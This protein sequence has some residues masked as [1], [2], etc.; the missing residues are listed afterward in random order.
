VFERPPKAKKPA[1]VVKASDVKKF[2]GSA[3]AGESISEQIRKERTRLESVIDATNPSKADRQNLFNE[4]LSKLYDEKRKG[5]S[6]A[7]LDLIND[8]ADGDRMDLLHRGLKSAAQ[9]TAEG[10]ARRAAE[11]PG[12]EKAAA[13]KKAAMKVAL[14]KLIAS[15]A[16]GPSGDLTQYTIPQLRKMYTDAH[17]FSESESVIGFSKSLSK[18]KVIAE[19]IRVAEYFKK[20]S[21]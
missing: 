8:A 13:D 19:I 11:R 6:S 7:Q 14:A 9:L 16:S 21:K 5:A 2:F 15:A 10:E 18:D 3:A 12:I 4:R 20:Q 17:G 1:P